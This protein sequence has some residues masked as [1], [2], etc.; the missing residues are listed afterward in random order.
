MAKL[1][2]EQEARH[3]LNFGIARS[4][5]PEDARLAYDRLVEGRARTGTLPPA[6]PAGPD[7]PPP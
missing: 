1:T 6:A 7:A 3:A 5:L 2:P 4:D